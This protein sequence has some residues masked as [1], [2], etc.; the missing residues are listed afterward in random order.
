MLKKIMAT[1]MATLL[2]CSS[3]LVADDNFEADLLSGDTKSACEAILCLS[4]AERPEECAPSLNRYFS[5]NAKKW[6]D[7]IKK[8]ENFL[9]LCPASGDVDTKKLS[10]SSN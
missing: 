9:K 5:I 4:S 2:C 6:K 1:I 8:R 3:V 7:T 10:K